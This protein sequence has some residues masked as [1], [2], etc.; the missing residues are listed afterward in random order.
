MTAPPPTLPARYDEATAAEFLDALG[1]AD[2]WRACEIAVRLLDAG[3]P[4]SE[5]L[6]GLVGGAARRIGQLWQ[7]GQWSV[8]QEHAATA[9]NERVVAAVGARIPAGR[10]RGSVVVGCLDGEWHALPARIV[11]EVLRADGW[12]VT[13]LGA[14]VPAE[15]LASYLHEYGPDA[16]ALSCALP[17]HLPAAHRTIQAAQRTGTPVIAGGPGFGVDG[18]W[19][20]RLG[21]DAWAPGPVEAL[22]ILEREPWRGRAAAEQA[23]STGADAEYPALRERRGE[24]VGAAVTALHGFSPLAGGALANPL[25]T[26]PFEDVG[27]VVDFLAAAVY[28]DD[29]ELFADYLRWLAAALTARGITT[30]GLRTVLDALAAGLHDFPFA[31]RCLRDGRA[32]LRREP[33]IGGDDR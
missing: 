28:L 10:A 32:L 22:E 23:A 4:V 7:G 20:R 33:T 1:R 9:V 18:R 25:E 13:F 6:V 27:Q 19:A 15:H 24:L 5:V 21:V 26:D 30:G 8:A 11:A 12:G 2:E 3:V 16:V 17:I 31:L 14:S 29:A